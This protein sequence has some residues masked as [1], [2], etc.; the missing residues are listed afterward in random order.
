[1]EFYH[2]PDPFLRGRKLEE[3]IERPKLVVVDESPTSQ[4]GF[5]YL[6]NHLPKY[7]SFLVVIGLSSSPAT[8]PPEE[9]DEDN[10]REQLSKKYRKLCERNNRKCQFVDVEYTGVES[11][12]QSLCSVA[13][14]YNSNTMYL[15]SNINHP[16][17]RGFLEL[18]GRSHILSN[19]NCQVNYLRFYNNSYANPNILQRY[20][21]LREPQVK[22]I[23]EEDRPTIPPVYYTANEHEQFLED[24]KNL[25]TDPFKPYVVKEKIIL[26]PGQTIGEA[27]VE[28]NK[29][30]GLYY[31]RTEEM[32]QHK[33]ERIKSIL[34]NMEMEEKKSEENKLTQKDSN[35]K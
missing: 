4:I 20:M 8:F 3:P 22:R 33:V 9:T 1:M 27:L 25:P 19:C 11:F 14:E 26:K 5:T 2:Y 28:E 23:P 6:L 12:G 10:L 35:K 31:D 15:S 21:I 16:A 18:E 34:K 32:I 24:P 17:E 7:C 13:E 29:K 30:S